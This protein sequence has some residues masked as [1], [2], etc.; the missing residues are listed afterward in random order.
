METRPAPA[1]GS[2]LLAGCT[3]ARADGHSVAR[4]WDEAALAVGRIDVP[5]TEARN[6][7]HLSAAM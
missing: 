6:L 2:Y 7:F 4:V 5:T 3:P 1:P